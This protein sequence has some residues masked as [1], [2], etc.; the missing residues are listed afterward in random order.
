[1]ILNHKPPLDVTV[2]Q[3]THSIN[4]LCRSDIGELTRARVCAEPGD[5]IYLENYLRDAHSILFNLEQE[6]R[7]NR[8]ADDCPY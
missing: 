5:V 8:D 4:N 6:L 2:K 3:L 1:M 7:R